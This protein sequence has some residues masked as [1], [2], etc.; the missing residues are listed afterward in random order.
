MPPT[1][2]PRTVVAF[3]T[4]GR[5][6]FKTADYAR[7]EGLFQAAL[8]AGADELDCRQHL[9]RIYNLSNDWP[10]ALQQ[11]LWLREHAEGQLR[12]ESQLQ[13]A[14]GHF[15]LKNHEAAVAAFKEVL[16]SQPDHAE[17]RQRLLQISTMPGRAPG[18]EL[19]PDPLPGQSGTA[20][21]LKEIGPVAGP[22]LPTPSPSEPAARPVDAT[23]LPDE[24]WAAS[25]SMDC[26][27]N[28]GTTP[29]RAKAPERA[30]KIDTLTRSA[31]EV[32]KAVPRF[33]PADRIARLINEARAAFKAQDFD[34]SE[35]L[36]LDALES[37][38][39]GQTCRLH[40]ARIYNSRSEWAKALAQW[41]WLHER[42]PGELELQ[43]QV[44]RALFRL[45][46]YPQAAV[47]FKAVL[48]LSPHH[49]EAQRRLRAMNALPADPLPLR[50]SSIDAQ[51]PASELSSTPSN[52]EAQPPAAIAEAGESEGLSLVDEAKA[53]FNENKLDY[54]KALFIRAI[55]QGADE[56][57][58]RLHLA[59]IC[60]LQEEWEQ[61]LE[62]W[63]WLR[64]HDKGKLEPYLQIGRAELN[65]GSY[66]EAAEAFER[67]LALAPDHAEAQDRL[68]QAHTFRKQS[69]EQDLAEG[70]SWLSL[71]PEGLRWQLA[72]D[73]LHIGNASTKA[74]IDMAVE[75]LESLDR[76]IQ[77]FGEMQGDMIRHRQLYALQAAGQVEQARR[78]LRK[79]RAVARAI[80]RRTTKAIQISE[81]DEAS[82]PGVDRP[83]PRR[84]SW[85]GAE[86]TAAVE[87]FR[88]QGFDGAVLSVLNG[89]PRDQRAT[90]LAGLGEAL[91]DVDRSAAV[92][93]YWLAF[94]ANPSQSNARLLS[95]KLHQS[96]DLANSSAMAVAGRRLDGANGQ[97][98]ENRALA[99]D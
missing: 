85:R 58:C 67:V 6:A 73:A 46:R 61:A 93:A 70:G 87:V 76:L 17:A 47:E 8:E 74:A 44:A 42:E 7:S 64:D 66:A 28:E 77:A 41:R 15:R 35:R 12:A 18:P 1:S 9:A 26:A 65:R 20:G 54:S 14:R 49:A 36:F 68:Q 21:R 60:N 86:T 27:R 24:G 89:C 13:V 79:V 72:K 39:D 80:D 30:Q 57:V 55:E 38:A 81:R 16:A 32:A 43:L 3:L 91:Q 99:E 56:A 78:E 51:Q 2:E 48:Q 34:G 90:A 4:E 53:A 5:A 83:V 96:G 50:P 25:E 98:R 95:F 37:G 31:G 94:G 63:K 92:R 84:P 52:P 59:R 75:T 11:W 40:L 62:H 97:S 82:K 69:E 88:V 22:P 33:S 71:V 29:D 10:K 23:R 19:R 45:K